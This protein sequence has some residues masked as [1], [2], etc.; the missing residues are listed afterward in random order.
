MLEG[1]PV[2]RHE[3]AVVSIDVGER[4][5]AVVLH[6]EEPILMIE[7]LREPQERHGAKCRTRF[8]ADA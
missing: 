5:E 1:V 2:A 7:R 6:L 4:S 3:V 8:W